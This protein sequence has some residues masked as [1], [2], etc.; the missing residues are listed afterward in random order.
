MRGRKCAGIF[1]PEARERIDVKETAV[2]DVAGGEPP[3]AELV[4]LAFKQMMQRERLGAAVRARPIG[5]KSAH[6]DLIPSRDDFQ[7]RFEG[8][9]LLT[10]GMT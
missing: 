8:R 3:V 10:A 2:V 9:R 4:V 6:N 1:D 5:G 7:F